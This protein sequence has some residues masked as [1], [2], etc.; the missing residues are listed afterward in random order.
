MLGHTNIQTTQIY[1]RITNAKIS[2][3]MALFAGKV[4]NLGTKYAVSQ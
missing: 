1:A 4:K 2:D 3:D